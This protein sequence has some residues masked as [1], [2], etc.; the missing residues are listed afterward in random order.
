MREFNNLFLKLKL[1]I[2]YVFV[3]KVVELI[4]DLKEKHLFNTI[5]QE[6]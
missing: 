5:K 4:S 6:S 3:E 1:Y 2:A